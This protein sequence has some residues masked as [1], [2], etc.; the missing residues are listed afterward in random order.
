MHEFFGKNESPTL[1]KLLK[2]LKVNIDF[3]YGMTL[4]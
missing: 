4:I 3:P 1:R 2:K